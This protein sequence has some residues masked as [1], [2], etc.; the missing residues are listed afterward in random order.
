MRNLK[1]DI[2]SKLLEP[3]PLKYSSINYEIKNI[4]LIDDNVYQNE[5][6][7][8]S[9]NSN[10]LAI[11]YNTNSSKK[12]LEDLLTN[13]FT[14]I[15]RIGFVFNDV[16]MD[17][18]EFL[19]NQLFFTQDD[20]IDNQTTYSSNLQFMID[21]IKKFNISNID[22]LVCNGLNYNDW[23][24]YF[25][26]LNKE[27]GVI[28]GASENETGN[29]KY[30][31]DWVMESTNE[32]VVEIYWNSQITNY[33]TTLVTNIIGTSMTLTNTDLNRYAWPITINGGTLVTPVVITFGENI[34]LNSSS[35]YFIIGSEYITIDG[36]NFTVIIDGV[37]NF[38]GLVRNGTSSVSGY[39]NIIL[40]NINMSTL[41][42]SYIS[43]GNGW[44]CQPYFGKNISTNIYVNNCNTDSTCNSLTLTDTGL[45]LGRGTNRVI[46]N[47]SSSAG[48]ISGGGIFGYRCT[49]CQANNCFSTGIINGYYSLGAG[50]IFA[51]GNDKTNQAN[52]CYSTGNIYTSNSYGSGGI[53]GESCE[54]VVTNCYSRGIIGFNG[55]TTCGGIFG[56]NT[57]NKSKTAINC[58]SSGI[59]NAGFGIGQNATETNCYVANGSWS[60]IDA[61]NNL[62]GTPTYDDSDNLINPIG[63][64]W[65]DIAPS[66]NS[67]PWI[68]ATFGYSPYTTNL[69]TTFTQTLSL[70][71]LQTSPALNPATHTY[72]IISINNQVPSLFPTISI[73]AS[74]EALGGAISITPQTPT[75]TYNIK[76]MQNSN[77]TITNFD[78]INDTSC[79]NKGTKIL[80]YKNGSEQYIKI[81]EL[82]KGDLVKT[83]ENGYIKIEIIGK[84]NMQ[85]NPS[86]LEGS[87]YKCGDL[88]VTGHHVLLKDWERRYRN[89]YVSG[90]KTDGKYKLKAHQDSRFEKIVNNEVYEIYNLVLEGN[91]QYGIWADGILTE[92]VKKRAI[93]NGHLKIVE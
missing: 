33:S 42:N 7:Y 84:N 12:E 17:Y 81:E 78:L 4:L 26:L 75:G 10:T 35:Q 45:I 9:V 71:M 8:D 60:D 90:R 91:K 50:G 74:D 56:H 85:N 49:N 37:K 93:L 39:S 28:V 61:K 31:G 30:G 51:W 70:N 62:T 13:N 83:L 67:I 63:S 64:T 53:C 48:T 40:Q 47:N 66:D 69:T 76:V 82:K 79:F 19:D 58:Y 54:V 6:L 72:S 18:K 38:P 73:V 92:T 20:L 2:D 1:Q 29:L 15:D 3:I 52:N 65:A 57:N 41:N 34:T 14:E 88:I 44:L 32:N 89:K 55:G 87:M 36:G 77:Y 80:C 21:L 24:K 23:V 43:N 11:K 68:F 22:Y 25:N 86:S 59:I 27:T 16:F 46:C 5:I